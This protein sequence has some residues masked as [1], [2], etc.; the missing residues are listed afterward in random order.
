MN[1]CKIE[2]QL[3][4]A[5]FGAFLLLEM[6]DSLW[7]DKVVTF[8]STNI[9]QTNVNLF[10]MFPKAKMKGKN[11]WQKKMIQWYKEWDLVLPVKWV[12]IMAD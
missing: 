8:V 9:A 7:H 1:L 6:T 4:T 12:L 2:K 10:I 3:I 11:F 5:Y